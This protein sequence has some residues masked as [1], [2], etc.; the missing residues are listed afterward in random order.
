[1]G[2]E[3][4]SFRPALCVLFALLFTQSVSGESTITDAYDLY[5]RRFAAGGSPDPISTGQIEKQWSAPVFLQRIYPSLDLESFGRE[6]YYEAL[7][8]RAV[9]QYEVAEATYR[10]FQKER[11]LIVEE[12]ARVDIWRTVW[13]QNIEGHEQL[14]RRQSAQRLRYL[15]R[16]ATEYRAVFET[17]DRIASARLRGQPRFVNLQKDVYRMYSVYQLGLGHVPPAIDILEKYARF[18]DVETEWPLHYYL[19]RAY[20]SR[21]RAAR[22]DRG[23]GEEALSAMRQQRNLHFLRAVDL[24]YGQKSLE[25]RSTIKKIRRE[26]L[27]SPRT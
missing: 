9:S 11:E 15:G 17:L 7:F 16:L 23:V 1:M 22:P 3:M 24:K 26:E 13:W 14:D 21:Y 27:G 6:A 18:P 2:R 8:R 25:F 20:D 12:R 5:M 19:S 10:E 4:R